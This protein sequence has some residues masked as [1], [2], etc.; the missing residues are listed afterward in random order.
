M[1]LCFLFPLLALGTYQIYTLIF[2]ECIHIEVM[3]SHKSIVLIFHLFIHY[4]LLLAS[5]TQSEI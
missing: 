5:I 2:F 1:S 4:F 3:H